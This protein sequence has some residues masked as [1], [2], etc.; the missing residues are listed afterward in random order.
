MLGD[1]DARELHPGWRALDEQLAP[2]EG[3]L[4]ILRSAGRLVPRREA[5]VGQVV[6]GMGTAGEGSPAFDASKD[7]NRFDSVRAGEAALRV[8][9][10]E[11]LVPGSTTFTHS[12]VW[13]SS[14]RDLYG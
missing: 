13:F 5:Q 12:D 7:A 3:L 9:L 2:V 10:W 14:S 8:H 1:G 6:E 11:P 4:G